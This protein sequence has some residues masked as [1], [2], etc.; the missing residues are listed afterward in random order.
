MRDESKN[1]LSVMVETAVKGSE[2]MAEDFESWRK[3]VAR[4]FFYFGTFIFILLAMPFIIPYKLFRKKL[5]DPYVKIQTELETKWR[6]ESSEAALLALRKI[7]TKIQLN[8]NNV[9][10]MGFQIEPYGKI[11]FFEYVKVSHLLY[12][13]ELQHQNWDQANKICDGLLDNFQDQN[14]HKS[15]THT[16]WIVYKAKNH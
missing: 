11:G 7:Y 8:L 9:M 4:A 16:E 1:L 14:P 5:I 3:P 13:W 10:M 6:T 2:A 12:H 15:K